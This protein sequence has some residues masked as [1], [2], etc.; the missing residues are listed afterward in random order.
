MTKLLSKNIIIYG[1]TNAL[2]SL[3]P[4]LMLPIL[5]AYLSIEDFGIL[6]LVETTILFI[7]P[8]V[9]LNINV[10]INV[11][12]FKVD[13]NI[14]KKYITNALVIS[15]ISFLFVFLIMFIFKNLLSSFLH[16]KNYLVLLIVLFASLRIIPSVI[17][18]LYQSKQESIKFAQYSILQTIID[19]SLSYIFVVIYKLGYIG[20][21]EGT[22]ISFFIFSIFGLYLLCKMDY[23]SKITFKYTKDILN[24]GIPLIPH[25]ISGTIMAMSDRYFISYYIGNEQVGLYTI[26]YQIS[27]LMLLLSVSVNQAWSPM[28]F[29]L[30]KDKN[31]KQ[32]YRFTF[33]LFTLFILAAILIYFFKDILFFIFV[34][35][36][37]YMAKEYFSWLLIGF[38]FQSFYFLVTNLL[39]FEKRTKLLATMTFS[40]AILNLILNYILILKFGTIGVAYATAITWGLFFIFV[41]IVDIKLIRRI[42]L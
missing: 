21:L 17:L 16:I 18:G 9:L 8:F 20:R 33:Y 35:K 11:E 36:K 32:I 3:V 2:K 29:K 26:A 10:A 14:L 41:S 38:L 1:G 4:L 12:Y 30:L 34:D 28:L 42:Y 5:T 6:S 15:F 24:F 7:T 23:L 40:G 22:Y 31:I 19:F 27:A 25:A 13:H 37:F 39:F